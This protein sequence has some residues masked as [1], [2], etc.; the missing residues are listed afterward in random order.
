LVKLKTAIING[1][2]EDAAALTEE[3]LAKKTPPSDIVTY[4][5]SAGMKAVGE[6]FESGEFFLSDM[7]IAADAFYAGYKIVLPLLGKDQKGKGSGVVMG[8]VAGDI[9]TIGKD[10]VIPV[11][12]A[13]GFQVIDLGIDVPAK[14]FAEKIKETGAQFVFISSFLSETTYVEVPKIV[15]EIKKA[16]IRNKVK[17]FVGG[18]ATTKDYANKVGA[19]GWGKDA[20]DAIKLVKQYV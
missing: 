5:L 18:P 11:M 1:E 13:E 19:D 8:V 7:L 4:G 12:Q 9:H 14:K 10:I 16:G 15:E 6:K 17:I 2:E 3:A 20:W